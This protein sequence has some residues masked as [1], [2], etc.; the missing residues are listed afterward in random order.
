MVLWL[1]N[2]V[3]LR[4]IVFRFTESVYIYFTAE[5]ILCIGYA[6]DAY[7]MLVD[8]FFRD[9]KT[10]Y[11]GILLSTLADCPGKW[12]DIDRFGGLAV[13]PTL[14]LA[15]LDCLK[16]WCRHWIECDYKYICNGHFL[17]PYICNYNLRKISLQLQITITNLINETGRIMKV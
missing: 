16:K 11:C 12:S 13:C 14:L 8:E 3:L 17:F 6:S 4:K 9:A 5:V 7:V 10:S 15:T 2:Q 1:P